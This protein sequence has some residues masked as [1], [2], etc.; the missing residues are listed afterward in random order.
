MSMTKLMIKAWA[1]AV[2][3]PM[4]KKWV[5]EGFPI[6]QFGAI[7]VG[8]GISMLRGAGWDEQRIVDEVV[9]PGFAGSKPD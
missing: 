8:Y 7:L 6:E 9:K 5:T 3:K 4:A 1:E 2:L